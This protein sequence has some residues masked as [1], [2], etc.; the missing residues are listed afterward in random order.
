VSETAVARTFV[1]IEGGKTLKPVVVNEV[2]NVDSTAKA[3]NGATIK[4]KIKV[5]TTKLSIG[6]DIVLIILFFI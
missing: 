4:D 3:E 2:V 1:G 6:E 5:A